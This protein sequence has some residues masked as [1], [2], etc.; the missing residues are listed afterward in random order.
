MNTLVGNC[1]SAIPKSIEQAF[2]ESAQ[3]VPPQRSGDDDPDCGERGVLWREGVRQQR[4]REVGVHNKLPNHDQVLEPWDE[5]PQSAHQAGAEMQDWQK[6]DPVGMPLTSQRAHSSHEPHRLIA[7]FS[8]LV[9]TEKL[10]SQHPI[11]TES[12]PDLAL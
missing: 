12:F 10:S 4:N 1:F 5:I 6:I 7:R 3:Q 11:F 9:H 8:H 2:R